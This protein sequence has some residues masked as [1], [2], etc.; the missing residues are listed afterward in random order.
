MFNTAGYNRARYNV[1]KAM[2]DT[3]DLRAALVEWVD[4]LIDTGQ[5]IPAAYIV[6]E[7]V[8]ARLVAGPALFLGA[9]YRDDLLG[10]VDARG[11]FF[12][13]AGMAERSGALLAPSANYY[14]AYGLEEALAGVFEIGANMAYGAA[15]LERMGASAY[16]SA[17]YPLPHA[18]FLEIADGE[19]STM[20][21]EI[22]YA[23]VNV[24]IPPGSTLVIDSDNYV[25][26]LDGENVIHA[27][28]GDWLWLDRSVYD[29]LLESNG[30]VNVDA[31]MLYT[32]R[33]L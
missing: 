32:E 14:A 9:R 5:N 28:S 26:L 17:D 24:V 27:Q 33:W 25:V 29:V 6:A 22:T 3:L 30:Q 1:G 2:T 15:V 13:G 10:A 12:L 16:P 7:T 11:V 21:F 20:S 4:S 23:R 19:V 8:G 18:L 31:E